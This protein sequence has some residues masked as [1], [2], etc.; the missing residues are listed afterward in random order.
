VTIVQQLERTHAALTNEHTI[1][2]S[3]KRRSTRSF[4]FFFFFNTLALDALLIL[5][6]PQL[7]KYNPIRYMG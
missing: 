1:H 4:F 2:P 6:L 3:D 7:T 5:L